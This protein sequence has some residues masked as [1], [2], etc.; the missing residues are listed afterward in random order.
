MFAPVRNLER[1]GR[2]LVEPELGVCL[3]GA[4]EHVVL[5]RE[6]RQ[7]LV[8]LERRDRTRRVVRVV[9]PD[10]R[11]ARPRLVVDR[12]EVGQ[13]AVLLEQRQRPDL[14]AGEER[15][16]LVDGIAGLGAQR[17]GPCP[18]PRSSTTCARRKIASLLAERR[19]RSPRPGRASTPKRRRPRRRSPRAARAGPARADSPP[20]RRA[21]S[22]QRAPGS[23]ARSA[24]SGRPCRSRASRRLAPPSGASPRR[25]RTNG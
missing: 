25:C 5:E 23:A 22:R 16:A 17:R 15:A 9:D 20:S 7:P 19:D 11:G 10:E 13:E 4:D 14:G 3:V 24:R 6:L 2:R 12:V 1:R 18:R 21:P 8:E